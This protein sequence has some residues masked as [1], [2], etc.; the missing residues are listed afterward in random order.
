MGKQERAKK[1]VGRL[2]LRREV[3]RLLSNETLAHVRGGRGSACEISCE[4][5]AISICWGSKGEP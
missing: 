2:Q 5:T 3:I 1:E 4:D